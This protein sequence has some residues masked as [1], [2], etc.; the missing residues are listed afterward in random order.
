MKKVIISDE[1]D[2]NKML[3]D[4][5]IILKD[6]LLF[7]IRIELDNIRFKFIHYELENERIEYIINDFHHIID[8]KYE[9]KTLNQYKL[10]VLDY[11][12]YYLDEEIM[13]G[14]D[15]TRSWEDFCNSNYDE[16]I[17]SMEKDFIENLR[18]ELFKIINT[19]NI[20]KNNYK[21][22]SISL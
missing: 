1:I 16:D 6:K 7:L 18:N 3:D 9:C 15:S 10:K 20:D 22:K 19:T 13:L 8:R 12:E 2:F 11:I 21:K 17:F 14:S 5:K 4:Y